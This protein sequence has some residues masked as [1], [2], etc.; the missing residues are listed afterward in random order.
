ME[1]GLV[2]RKPAGFRQ[3]VER[4]TE[5]IVTGNPGSDR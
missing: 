5:L 4:E 3:D 2:P 1:P